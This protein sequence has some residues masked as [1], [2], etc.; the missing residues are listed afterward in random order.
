MTVFSIV[1][2]GL[3]PCLPLLLT[4]CAAAQTPAYQF[5]YGNL[6]S[7][8]AYSD[9][10]QDSLQSGARTPRQAYAFARAAQHFDFLGISEHNHASAGMRYGRWAQGHQQA[11][12]ANQD[13]QF[14]AL[15]GMEW[16]TISNGGHALIYGYD[17]LIGWETGQ[18][19]DRVW[20][21]DYYTLY[22][23]VRHQPGAIITLA[24]PQTGDYQDLVGSALNPTADSLIVGSAFRSGP[25]YS[26]AVSYGDQSN[27]SYETFWRKALATGYH[28]GPTYDHDNHYT[29]FG[30]TTE[31]RLVV[32]APTLNRAEVLGALKAR[33]FFASDDWNA[34]LTLSLNQQWPMGTAVYDPAL[35]PTLNVTVADGD[36][37]TAT[38][39]ELWRGVPGSGALSV[40]VA[41]AAPGA[42]A[43]TWTDATL[44]PGDAAYYYASV[45]Q[46]DGDRL[47]SAP[48]WVSRALAPTGIT[49]ELTATTAGIQLWPNPAQRAVDAYVTVAG[50]SSAEVIDALGRVVLV[51]ATAPTGTSG[52]VLPTAALAPGMYAVRAQD[53][54]GRTLAV[55]SLVVQ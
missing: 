8:T 37:E 53:A 52:V 42:L 46:P 54:Y 31:G 40:R 29:T 51:A 39:V 15:Y 25:A 47:L 22:R 24:H 55:Q 1:R 12:S 43:L 20:K 28:I 33:R 13:G 26:R 23:V 7:H 50:A 21:G 14:V 35:I 41:V 19:D 44:A 3:L 49:D 32:L 38:A 2:R 16:G 6:H 11:D 18:Y 30:R 45:R 17:R 10:N 5:Y 36:G 48:I 34:Q 4:W 27:G 9:G